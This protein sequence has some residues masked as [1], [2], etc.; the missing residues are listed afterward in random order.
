M[1]NRRGENITGAL[2]SFNEMVLKRLE[3]MKEMRP[4]ATRAAIVIP[5]GLHKQNK[6]IEELKRQSEAQ[7]RAQTRKLG[8]DFTIIEVPKDVSPEALV[9]T[10]RDARIDIAEISG[11]WSGREFWATL[12]AN[13]IAAVSIMDRARDGALLSGWTRG[14]VE[15]AVRLAA[16]VVRG[17][18]AADL[19]VE[20]SIDYR[21]YVN[22][23]TARTLGI[24]VPPAI[25]M[26]ANEVFE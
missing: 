15:S 25:L 22:L 19:P 18:R 20:R 6:D 10:L 4:S 16:K 7:T 1:L 9:R 11:V 2:Y 3:L 21:F 24:T 5:Q 23:S 26:R 14:Y 12:A 13:G 17:Q 8:L